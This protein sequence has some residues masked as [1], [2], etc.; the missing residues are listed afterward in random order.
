[1]VKKHRGFTVTNVAQQYEKSK[2]LGRSYEPRPRRVR[3]L[4]I[5]VDP[6]S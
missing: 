5:P 4:A 2:A 1:M 3:S 6:D